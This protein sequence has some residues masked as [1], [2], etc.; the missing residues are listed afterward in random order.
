MS[1]ANRIDCFKVVPEGIGILYKL[2][3]YVKGCDLEPSLTELVNLRVSQINGC[4]YCIDFHTKE[5]RSLGESELRLRELSNWWNT[6]LYSEREREALAW[7]ATVTK[8]SESHIPDEAYEQARKYFTPR[9]L[10]N[11]TLAAI[12]ANAW[13]RIIVSFRMPLESFLGTKQI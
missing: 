2:E 13:N 7:A 3:I 1:T 5:A 10:V 6:A 4:A 8:I 9:E 12:A 11:L